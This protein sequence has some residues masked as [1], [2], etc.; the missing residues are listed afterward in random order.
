[1]RLGGEARPAA[2]EGGDAAAERVE[3]QRA[4]AGEDE[5]EE[6]EAVED[7]GVA[8]VQER[9]EAL[10]RVGE[11]I[12]DGHLAGKHEGDRAGEEAEGEKRAAEELEHAGEPGSENSATF[13]PSIAAGKP[14]SFIVPCSMNRSAV[15]MR[16]TPRAWATDGRAGRSRRV[17]FRLRRCVALTPGRVPTTAAR[18]KAFP[19]LCAESAL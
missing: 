13:P 2:V 15:T 3:A 17:S 6:D 12:G 10:R 8:A 7:R 14:K 4:G 9:E 11:E 5:I 1:M 16:S 18:E 19:R